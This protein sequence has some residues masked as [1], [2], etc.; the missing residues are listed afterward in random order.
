MGA[1]FWYGISHHLD[2]KPDARF[3]V[4]LFVLINVVCLS[5]RR[6]SPGPDFVIRTIEKG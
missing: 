5:F 4:W 1:N 6:T 2:V 3:P